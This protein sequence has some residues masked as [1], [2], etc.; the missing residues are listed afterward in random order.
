[1]K[2][3]I[4][5]R[6]SRLALNQASMVAAMLEQHGAAP[7]IVVIKTQGDR[8]R[9]RPFA[10]VGAPGVFVREIETALVEGAVDVGVHSFKDVPSKS[11]PGLF[12]AAVPERVDP[13]DRLLV[14]EE[15]HEPENG[16]LPLIED[17]VIGSASARRRALLLHERPDLRIELLRGNLPTRVRRVRDGDFDATLLAA[18]GLTRLDRES[19]AANAPETRLDRTGVVELRLDPERFV[20]APSQGAV[21][22][23][24][25]RDAHDVAELVAEIDDVSAHRAVAAERALLTLVEGGCQVPFGAWCRAIEGGRLRMVAFLAR[26]GRTVFDSAEADDPEELARQLHARLLARV[27]GTEAP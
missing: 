5:T 22:V 7:E 9:D 24:C 14:R 16:F 26:R 2:I 4:G 12:I 8:D 20:P 18:A 19:D 6:G 1:M 23:Q 21:A 10:E 13:A 17:A 27:A 11:E 15:A 3:R 25:R